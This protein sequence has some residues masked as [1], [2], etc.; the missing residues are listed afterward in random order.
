M[1]L[2]NHRETP[3]AFN[4][5][6]NTSTVSFLWQHEG[7]PLFWKDEALFYPVLPQLH[8]DPSARLND[9]LKRWPCVCVR[10]CVYRRLW[11]YIDQYFTCILWTNTTLRARK[12]S[13][14]LLGRLIIFSKIDIFRTRSLVG[15]LI[16]FIYTLY[17]CVWEREFCF[18]SR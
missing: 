12:L 5:F 14:L 16:Y 4:V 8:C 15:R 1:R 17:I 18:F 6:W 2:S 11:N 3:D 9:A 7:Q 13:T 10:V